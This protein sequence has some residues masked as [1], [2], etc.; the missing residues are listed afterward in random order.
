MGVRNKKE[1]CKD[2]SGIKKKN[3]RTWLVLK[4]EKCWQG[5]RFIFRF[6]IS[7]KNQ[8]IAKADQENKMTIT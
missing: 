1:K 8:G 5:P 3:F 6:F 7:K 4:E 2:V